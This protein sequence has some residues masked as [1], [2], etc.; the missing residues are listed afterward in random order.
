KFSQPATPLESL[1]VAREL[2]QE[3]L[4]FVYLGNILGEENSTPCLNCGEVLVKRSVYEV[5]IKALKDG[6]CQHCG[7]KI[8][9]IVSG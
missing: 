8:D 9:Y 5:E 2:A 1:Q 3:H 7:N 6:Y 4:N